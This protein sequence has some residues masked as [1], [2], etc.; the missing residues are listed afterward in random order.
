MLFSLA[1]DVISSIIGFIPNPENLG[2]LDYSLLNEVI[3]HVFQNTKKLDTQQ[4]LD[5]PD[6]DEKIKVNKL[7]HSIHALLTTGSFQV[8]ALEEYFNTNGSGAI[9]MIE[10]ASSERCL[11]AYFL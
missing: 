4:G 9:K 7:S 11:E 5:V 3:Q 10:F 1:D 2:N 6:F 8:G